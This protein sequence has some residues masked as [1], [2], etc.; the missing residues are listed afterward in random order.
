MN[1]LDCGNVYKHYKNTKV[2][3]ISGLNNINNKIIPIFNKYML[4]GVKYLDFKDFCKATELV[5]K[6]I[7]ITIEELEKI[8]II[9]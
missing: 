8:Q 9:K 7:H 5:N 3:M 2:L 4:K 6:G 1:T